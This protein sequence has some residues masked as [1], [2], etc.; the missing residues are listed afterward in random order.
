MLVFTNKHTSQNVELIALSKNWST[1]YE[2]MWSEGKLYRANNT[3]HTIPTVDFLN[4]HNQNQF[5]EVT[6]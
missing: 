3:L 6:R 1:Y 5:A 2:L 4:D